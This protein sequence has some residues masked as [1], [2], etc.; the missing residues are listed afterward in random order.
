M[1]MGHEEKAVFMQ[2]ENSDCPDNFLF[3]IVFFFSLYMKLDEGVN[4]MKELLF[5]V[6]EINICNTPMKCS[7]TYVFMHVYS[8]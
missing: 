4:Y 1:K 3:S 8:S 6:G 7:C 5:L 2:Q